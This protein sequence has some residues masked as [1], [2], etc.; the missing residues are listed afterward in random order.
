MCLLQNRGTT[1][2]VKAGHTHRL[3]Y[4]SSQCAFVCL[5]LSFKLRRTGCVSVYEFHV[6]RHLSQGGAVVLKDERV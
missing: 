6:S 4:K 5:D 3:L 1:E 2:E